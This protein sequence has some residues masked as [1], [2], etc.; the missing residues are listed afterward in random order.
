MNIVQQAHIFEKDGVFQACRDLRYQEKFVQEGENVICGIGTD[1]EEAV[2][3][4]EAAET[5]ARVVAN[6]TKALNALGKVKLNINQ[7][8]S[9]VN[10]LDKKSGG[11]GRRVRVG[12]FTEQVRVVESM[13][14]GV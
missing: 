5:V 12:D 4:L 1:I 7:L 6:N 13:L 2:E 8:C 14:A 10:I 3:A 9:I 11:N